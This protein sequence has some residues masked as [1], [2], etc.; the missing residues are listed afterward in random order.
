MRSPRS[1]WRVFLLPRACSTFGKA[2]E[3]FAS[4]RLSKKFSERTSKA[5]PWLSRGAVMCNHY[6]FYLG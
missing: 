6:Y 5:F 4:F 1:D 3:K 2:Q